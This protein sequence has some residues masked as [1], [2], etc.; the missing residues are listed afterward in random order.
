[1]QNYLSHI[2]KILLQRTPQIFIKRND[3][4]LNEI[5]VPV[6]AQ[7]LT[8]GAQQRP[9]PEAA[10][11]IGAEQECAMKPHACSAFEMQA[12]LIIST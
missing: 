10:K 11:T 2:E 6:S 9:C 8:D 3:V 1:M 5:S 4:Q 12:L 7:V